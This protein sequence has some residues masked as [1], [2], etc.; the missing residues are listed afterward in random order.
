MEVFR[1]VHRIECTYRR[2]R[3][4]GIWK[5][6]V[7]THTNQTKIFT[8]RNSHIQLQ[9]H[10]NHTLSMD[11]EIHAII[12]TQNHVHSI[13]DTEIHV[14]VDIKIHTHIHRNRYTKRATHI[15][16]QT[17]TKRN[18]T[19][20]YTPV[21]GRPTL[22]PYLSFHFCFPKAPL[23]THRARACSLAIMTLIPSLPPQIKQ[24][25]FLCHQASL[26]FCY[27]KHG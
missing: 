9:T 13:T 16:M 18:S 19:H 25:T 5:M 26:F 4:Q 8:Q 17:Q 7:R 14:I 2:F 23:D 1:K 3:F 12:Y 27:I 10:G 22:G 6:F 15:P 20:A 11:T 21:H 24:S